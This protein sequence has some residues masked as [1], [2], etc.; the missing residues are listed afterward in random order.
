MFCKLENKWTF[1]NFNPKRDEQILTF[2]RVRGQTSCNQYTHE[3]W[4]GAVREYF[5]E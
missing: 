2:E 5:R 3:A 4:I 1:V